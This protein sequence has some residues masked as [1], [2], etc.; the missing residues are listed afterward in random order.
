M[1]VDKK[2]FTEQVSTNIKAN[3]KFTKFFLNFTNNGRR[4]NR[5]ID[6]S[7]K[8]WDKR[9][10]IS[11]IKMELEELKDKLNNNTSRFT[12]MTP[13]N[14]IAEILYTTNPKYN[15]DWG[16][17]LYSRYKLYCQNGIGKKKIKDIRKIDIDRLI[18]QMLI[19]GHSKQTKNGCSVATIKKVI[20]QSLKPVLQYAVDNNIIIKVP[21]I[22][23]PKSKQKTKKTVTNAK[24]KLTI[25]FTTITTLYKDEPFY[26][27]L[28]LFALYGRRWNEIRTLQW[29]DINLQNN[30]YMIKAQ[31]NKIGLDQTYELAFPMVEAL[32][33][34][35]DTKK[36]LVFKSPVTQKELYPPKNQ[37]NKIKEK[38]NIPELTMHY[39]R[40]ILVSA[41]GEMG[42]A[43][44]ILSASLGHT[45][46]QTV[47]DYYLSV[48]HTQGSHEANKTISV[49]TNQESE[50]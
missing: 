1:A 29:S 7:N 3:K 20:V 12:D 39:F 35:K 37:L 46:L 40:H 43:N 8:D 22:D 34:I 15:S 25:L 30:T 19:K 11:K 2:Q 27:A 48:N 17:D 42:T 10:R 28:F 49:I 41:M 16:K 33:E 47:N 32:N 44:T 9:T 45:N 24:E 6:Y 38:S 26:R 13:L 21:P 23:L 4:I 36:G 50:I 5:V 14:I 18:Q 31:N